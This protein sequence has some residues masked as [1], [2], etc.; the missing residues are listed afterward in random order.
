MYV[1]KNPVSVIGQLNME[2]VNTGQHV[3]TKKSKH[4]KN[5]R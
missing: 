4:E 1:S 3:H 2:H 5:S